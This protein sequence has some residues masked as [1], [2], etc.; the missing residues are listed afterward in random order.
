MNA[1]CSAASRANTLQQI[2]SDQKE[3]IAKY[4]MDLAVLKG[5]IAFLL[6]KMFIFLEHIL[7]E[8]I[9]TQFTI[10]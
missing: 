2:V 1:Q 3:C 9:D 7:Q 10:R 4:K 5:N 8:Q 6:G